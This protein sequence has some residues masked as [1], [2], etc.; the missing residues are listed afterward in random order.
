MVFASGFLQA[1]FWDPENP[2]AGEDKTSDAFGYRVG[3]YTHGAIHDH[4]FAFKVDLDILGSQNTFKTMNWKADRLDN[5]YNNNG[6]P[7]DA[8]VKERQSNDTYFM[9][10]ETPAFEK[11]YKIDMERPKRWV[12]VNE[13]H[14]NKWGLYRGYEISHT[15]TGAQSLPDSFPAMDALSFSKYQCAVTRYHQEEMHA[16]DNDVI[17]RLR[18]PRVSIDKY[19]NGEEIVNQDIVLWTSV[20]FLHVPT[21]E[22]FPETMQTGAG[23]WLRPF[24]YFD[25]NPVFDLPQY[26]ESSNGCECQR[27]IPFYSSPCYAFDRNL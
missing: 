14:K 10:W 11:G 17:G 27:P 12:V 6:V 22:D 23:F 13:N 26:F 19:M 18:S 2:N 7:L 21:A 4:S 8:A 25:R 3:E 5:A 24:N 15:A 20:G 1:G 16:T 9:H